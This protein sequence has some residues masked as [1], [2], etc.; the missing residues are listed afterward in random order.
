MMNVI[1]AGE[2]INIPLDDYL[3]GLFTD[4]EAIDTFHVV[5]VFD[6][7]EEVNDFRA[8]YATDISEEEDKRPSKE[9][10]YTFEIYF[11]LRFSEKLRAE[12]FSNTKW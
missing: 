4:D 11:K 7:D 3:S 5:A 9:E 8:K 6:E 2:H 12:I 1:H 10:G